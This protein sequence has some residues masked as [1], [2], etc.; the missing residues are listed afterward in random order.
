LSYS[1]STFYVGYVQDRVLLT[2]CPGWFSTVILLIAASQVAGIIGVNHW[3][4]AINFILGTF[5]QKGRK[6]KKKQDISSED[7]S[8][9]LAPV[10]VAFHSCCTAIIWAQT[11]SFP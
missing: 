9:L 3:H 5:L 11:S 4:P 2:I 1:A 8:N 10:L 7:S 6:K